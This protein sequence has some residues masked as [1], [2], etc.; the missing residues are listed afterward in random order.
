MKLVP[1]ELAEALK[2]APECNAEMLV[3]AVDE[4]G[5]NSGDQETRVVKMCL[6]IDTLVSEFVQG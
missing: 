4:W 1:G 3:G 2:T 5:Q 6:Q